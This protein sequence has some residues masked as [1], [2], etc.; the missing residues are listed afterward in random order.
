MEITNL[1]NLRFCHD[2]QN[3]ALQC[4][5]RVIKEV[6]PGI[7]QSIQLFQLIVLLRHVSKLAIQI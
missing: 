5:Q 7:S 6:P 1:I 4:A 2:R 3:V